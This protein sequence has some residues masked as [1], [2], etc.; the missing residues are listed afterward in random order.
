MRM[1]ECG[2]AP[3]RLAEAE[4]VIAILPTTSSASSPLPL[5]ATGTQPAQQS[6]SGFASA[7]AAAQSSQKNENDA[8]G[9]GSPEQASQ[10]SGSLENSVVET[11]LRQWDGLKSASGKPTFSPAATAA[12]M[13]ASADTPPAV[14]NSTAKK[15][16]GNSSPSVPS[17]NSASALIP[18]TAQVPLAAIRV[19]PLPPNFVQPGTAPIDP[20]PAGATP[21]IF[22][23]ESLSP[24]ATQ[25]QISEFAASNPESSFVSA[26]PTVGPGA[27][28][29]QAAVP[30]HAALNRTAPNPGEFE[31]QS[32]TPE[33]FGTVQQGSGNGSLKL[34]G[35]EVEA[36]SPTQGVAIKLATALPDASPAQDLSM[37]TPI[38]GSSEPEFSFSAEPATSGG[39]G[40]Q[41]N[42]STTLEASPH[43]S[44]PA[45]VAFYE[46]TGASADAQS[47]ASAD[48]Q[49]S[50]QSPDPPASG[51]EQFV[52]Q[53]ASPLPASSPLSAA[54]AGME[55]NANP[56]LPAEGEAQS[57]TLVAEMH[58]PFLRPGSS[59]SAMQLPQ[60]MTAT[61]QSDD[62]TSAAGE[63]SGTAAAVGKGAS[64]S[65]LDA[66]GA[67]AA[68]GNVAAVKPSAQV[69]GSF[70]GAVAGTG[71]SINGSAP[72]ASAAITPGLRI[73]SAT[74]G[75][76]AT[77]PSVG[78]TLTPFS[79]FFSD[80]AS[81]TGSAAS[82]LPRMI[83]PSSFSGTGSHLSQIG[84]SA[85][86]DTSQQS[87]GAHGA[88]KQNAAAQTGSSSKQS[89]TESAVPASPQATHAN[90]DPNASQD[91]AAPEPTATQIPA[92]PS[93]TQGNLP[94]NSQTAPAPNSPPQTPAQTAPATS[95]V[96]A[97]MFSS[98][99][100]PSASEASAPAQVLGPVQAAQL[101][102]RAGQSEMRIGLNTTA[103]GSVEVRTTVRTSDVGL[104]IGSEKGDLHTLLA[105]E[106]PA[107]ANSLQQQNLRLNSVNFTQGFASSSNASGGGNSPQQRAFVPLQMAANSSSA[108]VQSDD[109]SE[110]PQSPAWSGSSN[111][112]ILA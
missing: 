89:A 30:N 53:L 96:P 40:L 34:M 84:A 92:P 39:N 62:S 79:V 24:S 51:R 74:A 66:P 9:S 95:G 12:R 111:F 52:S 18:H 76:S 93:S 56:R 8:V 1:Q 31:I 86:A 19:N 88:G 72:S 63:G 5:A 43:A 57:M 47:G 59:T 91:M 29:P 38:R 81:A 77:Q 99:A 104:V 68:S 109:T 61:D 97:Q 94:A 37:E 106:L 110:T 80:G 82:I 3:H 33:Q 64:A 41:L 14:S 7:L 13:A 102:T 2:R 87:S 112:S 107:V 101:L 69:A 105:N 4:A 73:P 85:A 44:S 10:E 32:G 48:A 6:L 22:T 70:A 35:A 21:A 11:G 26:A 75:I 15:A 67:L 83:L 27:A 78:T 90:S 55:A 100:A 20:S 103:F 71:H 49:S 65:I 25:L 36:Q 60:Q 16:G 98:A 108:E 17:S 46:Q 28:A 45:K 58:L 54:S 50:S 42:S 23:H